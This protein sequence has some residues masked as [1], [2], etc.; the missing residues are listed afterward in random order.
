[1][2]AVLDPNILVS[3]VISPLGVHTQ[4]LGAW[5]DEHF[6][7]VI[8]QAVLDELPEVLARP[9]SGARSPSS[10]STD[11]KLSPSSSRIRTRCR[12]RRAT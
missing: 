10:T 4:V 8:S 1:M 6:E 9:R 2:K 7:L 5:S 3:A 11:W 12:S